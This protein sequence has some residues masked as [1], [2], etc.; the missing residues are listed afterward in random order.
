MIHVPCVQG[1]S[2]WA[3]LRIGLPTASSFDKIITNK[4]GKLS[5]SADKYMWRLIAE[6][7]LGVALDDATSGFMERGTILEKQAVARYELQHDCDTTPAGFVLR[8]DRRAGASPDRFVGNDGLLEIKCPSAGVHVG[9]LLGGSSIAD[10]Y[11]AQ[12]QGQ[13]WIC[14]RD[15]VDT[16][17]HNPEMPAAFMRQ[18]RDEAYI[19][20]IAAAIQQFLDYMDESK[21][22]L[23]KGYQLFPDFA[24]PL[25]KVS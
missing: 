5:A 8:D 21:E 16:I 13:L 2:E 6:Q 15:Y 11:R 3:A 25:L 22:K 18:V 1:T 4:T 10:E 17:S 7:L 19:K 14:E 20:L 9:F 24:R 23:Q 12:C